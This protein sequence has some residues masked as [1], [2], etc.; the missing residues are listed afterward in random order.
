LLSN[1][2]EGALREIVMNLIAR[3]YLFL[4]TDQF[5]VVKLTDLSSDVLK[6]QAT[7][8]VKRERAQI[9]DKKKG[10]RSKGHGKTTDLAYDEA[11]Y[12][13]LAAKRSEI[14]EAKSLARFMVFS[15]SAIEEMAFYKPTTD[16]EFLAIKGVGENKLVNY[17]KAFID[18]IQSYKQPV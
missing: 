13:L 9:K 17:G 18:V 10:K 5:P 7:I 14:A 6:G 16:D 2:S 11:L 3:G 1:Y 8:S 15:N 4:T 12:D